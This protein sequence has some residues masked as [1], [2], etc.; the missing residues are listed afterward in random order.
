M[1]VFGSSFLPKAKLKNGLRC[2]VTAKDQKQMFIEK[3]L[4]KLSMIP[5]VSG[6]PNNR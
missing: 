3:G 2:T 5:A 1:Y 4:A 6:M